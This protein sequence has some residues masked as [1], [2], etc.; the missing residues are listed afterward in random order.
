M[1]RARVTSGVVL[2]LAFTTLLSACGKGGDPAARIGEDEISSAELATAVG[3]YRSI[4]V[5]QQDDCGLPD[6]ATAPDPAACERRVLG[7]LVV[8]RILD[9]YALAN[10]IEVQDAD[11]DAAMASFEEQYGADQ[12]L[13]AFADHGVTR[14]DMVDLVRSSLLQRAVVEAVAV[15]EVGGEAE[16]RD[17]YEEQLASLATIE[18]DHIL[19]SSEDE[20][21]DVFATVTAPGFSRRDFRNLADEVSTDPGVV[22]NHGTY[23]PVSA[24]TFDPA[25]A[26]GALELEPGEISEPVQTQFGWHVIRLESKEVPTFEEARGQLLGQEGQTAFVGWLQ[27]RLA[28]LDIEVNPGLGRFDPETLTVVRIR[29]TDPD[30]QAT[31]SPSGLGG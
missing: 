8:T 12:L 19:V 6:P 4:L 18:V 3:V 9:G 5:G 7:N 1:T 16:L 29:S 21:R 11:V 24:A 31:P 14:K 15:E 17:R 25:F 27:E 22:E 13:E 28:D 10:G 30:A 23:G 26:A 2:V 20:A